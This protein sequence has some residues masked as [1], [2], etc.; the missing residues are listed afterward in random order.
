MKT[1]TVRQVR[2]AF[3]TL[4]RRVEKGEVV[5]ITRHGK[6]VAALTPPPR[7]AARRPW[8]GRAE[9]LAALFPEPLKGTTMAG[10]ISEDRE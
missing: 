4:L 7:A 5:T 3:P 6:A 1:A 2:N 9:R 10:L 8:T